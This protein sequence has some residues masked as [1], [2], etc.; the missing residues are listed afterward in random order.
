MDKMVNIRNNN[1][2]DQYGCVFVCGSAFHKK[3]L[4]NAGEIAE[5]FDEINTFEEFNNLLSA[6]NGFFSV[7]ISGQSQ[8]FAAVDRIRSIPLFYAN[9][10]D[11][12]LVSNDPYW[13]QEQIGNQEIDPDARIEYLLTGYVTG[14]DTLHPDIFQVQAGESVCVPIR[15]DGLKYYRYYSFTKED[16]ALQNGVKKR[17]ENILSNVF[18]RL[19][20][21]ADDR[22]IIVPLSGGYDSRLIVTMLK[23]LGYHN[24]IA[25]TFGRPGNKEAYLSRRVAEQLEVQ[26]EFIEY[27]HDIWYKRIHSDEFNELTRIAGGLASRPNLLDWPAVWHISLSPD[28][29][30]DAIFVPGH[31][32][33]FVAGGHIREALLNEPSRDVVADII[34]RKHYGLWKWKSKSLQ[35]K[36]RNRI[37]EQLPPDG[38]TDYSDP[39]TAVSEYERWE[40]QERQAKHIQTANIY[41]FWGYDWWYPFWDAEFIDFWNEIPLRYRENKEFYEEFVDDFYNTVA[42]GGNEDEGL[43]TS[44]DVNQFYPD[45]WTEPL[46]KIATLPLIRPLAMKFF[47]KSGAEYDLQHMGW[48]GIMSRTQFRE[49]QPIASNINSYLVC[50]LLGLTDLSEDNEL[51]KKAEVEDILNDHY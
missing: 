42:G 31:T 43:E 46:L 12:C 48:F 2:W 21:V 49:L 6:L 41:N 28:F 23:K 3:K 17:F 37:L 45:S 51:L 9:I 33:D 35:D 7:I 36:L 15:G 11:T 4:L 13:I 27:N 10:F 14:R 32:G 25:V 34:I 16:I 50:H 8:V 5:L 20:G 30:D 29:P 22:T 24:I 40:W 26:W 47:E 39:R 1:G 19:I 38:A 18:K 44:E